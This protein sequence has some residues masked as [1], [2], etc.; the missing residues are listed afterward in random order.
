MTRV[1][2]A[3]DSFK[4]TLGAAAAA[5]AL[6]EGWRRVRPEDELLTVPLADGGEGTL[7]ALG[8]DLPAGCW[9]SAPVTG[10]DG[11]AVDAAWLLL[12][13]GTAV[14]EMARAAGLPLLERPDPLGATTRG[15][16]QLLAAV[17][18]DPAVH[19]VMLTLGGSATTDGGTGALAALGARFLDADGA[20]LP[21]GGGA[22]SRLARVDL[23]GLTPPP[24]GGVRCLVDVTAPL[25]G[26]LGAAGQFGPQKGADPGQVTELDAGLARLADLLGGDREAPGA[27]AAGGTAYG[28]AV[29][30]GAEF[31]SGAQAV[32]A[33]A[34]LDEALR[35]AALVV[36]G[37]GQFDAQS[38]RGKVVGDLVDRAAGAEVPVAVVAGRVVAAERLPVSRALSLTELAGS[39]AGAM[40]EPAHWLATAGEHLAREQSVST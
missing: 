29:C 12:P 30:W 9:R 31:V 39:V 14:V 2:I 33:A 25:L 36:T 35:G 22:L 10:P 6:A 27:G 8:H 32:A 23:T 40:A 11:R 5:E 28:F 1:V 15:L 37:E 34:G 21:P 18:A 3:P 4:G 24:A 26:P 16:G 17:A 20:E 19:R 7:E 38:L 13:D